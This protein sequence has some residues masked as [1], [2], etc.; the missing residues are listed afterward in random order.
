MNADQKRVIA[1]CKLVI[2]RFRDG[3][4]ECGK[5]YPCE[6]CDMAE[7]FEELLKVTEEVYNED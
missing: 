4:G 7:V 5:D 1:T 2:Q 3:H 6:A